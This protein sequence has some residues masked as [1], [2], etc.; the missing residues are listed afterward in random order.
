ML[1]EHLLI[2]LKVGIMVLVDDVPQWMQESLARDRVRE[3]QERLSAIFGSTTNNTTDDSAMVPESAKKDDA[4]ANNPESS[5]FVPSFSGLVS[6]NGLSRAFSTF[7][8]STPPS[9]PIAAATANTSTTTPNNNTNN[10]N[11][12]TNNNTS[13]SGNRN[14]L[15]ASLPSMGNRR[16]SSLISSLAHQ[17]SRLDRSFVSEQLAAEENLLGKPTGKL[18]VF[19]VV[20]Q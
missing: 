17:A 19:L 13:S 2:A 15:P 6:P 12:N 16:G 18:R 8:E 10:S 3:E 11:N 4:R 20:F 5:S 14:S 9:T 1:V 7:H